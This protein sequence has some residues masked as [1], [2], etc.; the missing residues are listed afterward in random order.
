MSSILI[1][2]FATALTL[3][4]VAVR[5]DDV[6]TSFDPVSDRPQVAQILKDGCAHMRR[7]FD[8]EDINLDELITTAMDDPQAIAGD[9]KVLQGHQLRRPARRLSRSICKN[10]T[11]EPRQSISA[12]SSPTT[13][14]RSRT[15][16]TM[17]G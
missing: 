6:K 4:Q 9:M 12:K 13:T 10:E 16:P 1:K 5:P 2:I 3:S 8:I 17:R 11:V 7:A 14:R 15:F